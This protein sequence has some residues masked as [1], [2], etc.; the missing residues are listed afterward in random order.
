M[1]KHQLP[2]GVFRYLPYIRYITSSMVAYHDVFAKH[3]N[4]IYSGAS[5]IS[6]SLDRLKNVCYSVGVNEVQKNFL[7]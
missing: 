4:A 7:T 6:K 2:A 3:K 5:K 1:L